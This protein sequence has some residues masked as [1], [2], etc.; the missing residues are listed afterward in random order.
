MGLAFLAFIPLAGGGRTP[1]RCWRMVGILLMFTLAE[2]FLSPVGLSLSTKLAPQAFRTQMVALF[3]L[4]VS[5]GT[6]LAGM[7]AG[8]YNPEN[9]VPYFGAIGLVAIVLGVGLAVAVPS[10]KKLMGGIR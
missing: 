5:L 7:L 3:F 1:L 8:Y 4:S 10:L 2:L 6:T 9:E